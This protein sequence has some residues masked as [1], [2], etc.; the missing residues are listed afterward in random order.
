[1]NDIENNSVQSSYIDVKYAIKNIK[2]ANGEIIF[3]SSLGQGIKVKIK[4]RTI[5]L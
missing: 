3:N 4:F 1:M 2:N 5:L